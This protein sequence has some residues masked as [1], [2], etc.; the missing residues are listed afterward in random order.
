MARPLISQYHSMLDILLSG[1]LSLVHNS[2]RGIQVT[3]RWVNGNARGGRYGA[4][5]E[6]GEI[7]WACKGPRTRMMCLDFSTHLLYRFTSEFY[8]AMHKLFHECLDHILPRPQALFTK[9]YVP[10]ECKPHEAEMEMRE[11]ELL[12]LS[13]TSPW[14]SNKL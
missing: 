13:P 12:V 6:K 11:K 2:V 14:S 10:L 7:L 3:L 8:L 9:A 4:S 5:K 1:D